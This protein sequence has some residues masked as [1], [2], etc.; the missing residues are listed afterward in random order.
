MA[1]FN[2]FI[3]NPGLQYVTEEILVNLDLRGL[4]KSRVVSKSLKILID[5]SQRIE[6]AKISKIIAEP[7]HST[8]KEAFLKALR[9]AMRSHALKFT[10]LKVLTDF[11]IFIKVWHKEGFHPKVLSDLTTRLQLQM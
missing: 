9:T 4:L 2:E 8:C 1:T 3:Q 10:D 5:N 11:L 6:I 7:C